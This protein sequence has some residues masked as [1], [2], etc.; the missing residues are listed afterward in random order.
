MVNYENVVE[1]L[2]KSDLGFSLGDSVVCEYMKR[3]DSG[4]V[5]KV[6]VRGI[7]ECITEFMFTIMT[8]KGYRYTVSKTEIFCNQV[9][10]RRS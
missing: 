8:D 6:L 3:S 7:I 5:T 10:M 9:T 1:K 4:R 2:K